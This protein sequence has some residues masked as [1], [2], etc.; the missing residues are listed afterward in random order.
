MWDRYLRSLR[1]KLSV[2]VEQF[3]QAISTNFPLGTRIS[4]PSG[5]FLLWVEKPT[6]CQGIATISIVRNVD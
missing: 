4:H 3:S 5:G 6:P 2:Q 1:R